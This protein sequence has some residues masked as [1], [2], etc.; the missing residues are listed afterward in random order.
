MNCVKFLRPLFLTE[1]LWWLLLY[2]TIWARSV[3]Y[4]KRVVLVKLGQVS[5]AAVHRFSSKQVFLKFSEKH[6]CWRL[7]FHKVA[8]LKT[9]L[10]RCFNTNVFPWDLQNFWEHLFLQNSSSGC[11]WRLTR[12]FKGVWNENRCDKYQIQLKKVFSVAKY[13]STPVREI[14]PEFFYPF[15]LVSKFLNLAMTKWFCYVHVQDIFIFI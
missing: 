3:S 5:E 8:I 1:Q 9:L 7:F 4:Q 2:V 6:L 11:L 15:N 13:S 10:K 14:I 12:I